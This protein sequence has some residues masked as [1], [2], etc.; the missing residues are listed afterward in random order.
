MIPLSYST[1]MDMT[2]N[3]LLESQGICID[4][5]ESI[6]YA[7]TQV[8]GAP[9]TARFVGPGGV[10]MGDDRVAQLRDG[11]LDLDMGKAV[12]AADSV[13]KA[14]SAANIAEVID[15]VVAA[16]DEVG[17]RFQTQEWYLAELVYAGEIAKQ[18]MNVLS[19]LMEAAS[20]EAGGTVV[21]GTVAGDL[22][23]L[24][25][26]IFITYAKSARFKFIDL[27]T[28]VTCE[29]FV[30][31]VGENKPLALGIS[32]LLTSTDQEVGRVIEELKKQGLRETLKVIIGGAALTER[33]AEEAGADAF[34]AQ[35]IPTHPELLGTDAYREFLTARREAVAERLNEFLD[36]RDV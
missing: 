17:K 18:V 31:A 16:L 24:G 15:A 8:N 14:R 20:S 23:D 34:G 32:C 22:H 7:D 6:Q 29:R 27:G 25:K 4:H 36:T 2:R 21:V 5:P 28:D 33:F 1:I 35:C 12:G 9:H 3:V 13:V 10:I 11:L 26:N 30:S 19:P